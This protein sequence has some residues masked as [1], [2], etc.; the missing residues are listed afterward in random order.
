MSL[1]GYG[2]SEA[3]KKP[4][5]A[6]DQMAEVGNKLMLSLG[7]DEYVTQGGDWGAIVTHRMAILYGGKS[8]KAWHT[9]MPIGRPPRPTS[10]PLEFL[11]LLITPW[12]A[13]EKIGLDRTEWFQKNER[14]YSTEQ[15]SKPQTLGYA[16]ADSPVGLLAW[17]YEKLITWT[18]SYPWDD[19][20]VLTWIALYWFSRAGPAASVR[21]YYETD[22]AGDVLKMMS[23]P[24]P[25]I[26]L[27]ISRFPK[28][29]LLLPKKWS[30]RFGNVVFDS[31]HER[32][33]HFAAHEQPNELVDDLRKMFGKSGPAFGVVT[34]KSG[35][36]V[37]SRL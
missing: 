25:T 14:G 28:E 21:I 29:L 33:G 7:Y 26:P 35:Y 9:N 23:R 22:K 37:A 3:P 1:P 12:T 30:A 13:T 24:P 27:G 32:G 16:L 15:S 20:E 36:D 2:F 5:F 31:T 11:R 19:D 6:H 10:E 4:G 18:D 8:D 34:G 17:I